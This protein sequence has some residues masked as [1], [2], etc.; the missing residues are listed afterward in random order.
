[1]SETA[2]SSQNMAMV[3][4]SDQKLEYQEIAIPEPGPGQILV[5]ISHAAQNPTDGGLC[6]KDSR[7]L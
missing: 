6:Y 7:H 5:E 4:G 1:M 3:A 2:S